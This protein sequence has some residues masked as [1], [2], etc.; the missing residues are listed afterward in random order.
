MT[1]EKVTL[2]IVPQDQPATIIATIVTVVTTTAVPASRAE[3]VINAGHTSRN[4]RRRFSTAKRP[5][6]LGR[7][8]SVLRL[9]THSHLVLHSSIPICFRGMQHGDNL[10]SLSVFYS[11]T[12]TST[13]YPVFP[14]SFTR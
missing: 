10:I 9:T 11:G 4:G 3:Y 7:P 1:K 6:S 13:T 8:S 5:D 12:W 2:S 14:I